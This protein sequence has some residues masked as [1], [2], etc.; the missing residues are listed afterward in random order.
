M[1]CEILEACSLITAL[2]DGAG[3]APMAAR[4]AEIATTTA[5][6]HLRRSLAAGKGDCVAL[7]REAAALARE[8]IAA[9]AISA[10]IDFRHY[11]S[12][13]LV[14]ILTP[15]GG[16]A[17]QLGDGVIVVGEGECDWSWV[18]WPQRGEYANT[19]YFLT[20]DLALVNLQVDRLSPT[21]ADIALMSDGLESLALQYTRQMVHNP[22]FKGAFEPLLQVGGSGEVAQLSSALASFLSSDRVAARTDDDVALILATRRSPLILDAT[23]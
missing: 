5:V 22:F 10:S 11:A 9:E 17:L 14:A 1:A 6:S 13:L 2:A 21:I 20:D 7:L 4:G 16:G 3:S 18:F 23:P 12:T 8:T 19:T 15:E